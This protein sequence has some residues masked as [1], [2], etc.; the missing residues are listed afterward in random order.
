MFYLEVLDREDT[1]AR[2]RNNE[3][4]VEYSCTGAVLLIEILMEDIDLLVA[5]N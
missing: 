4:L 3:F 5:Q 1:D 2:A